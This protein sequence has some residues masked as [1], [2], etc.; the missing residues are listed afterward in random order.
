MFQKQ[1]TKYM[2]YY[3]VSK[4]LLELLFIN[5]YVIY[6]NHEGRLIIFI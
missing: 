4:N 1:G 5:V 3:F 2:F 6:D